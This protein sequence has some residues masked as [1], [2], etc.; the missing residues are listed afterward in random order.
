[1]E[2]E[3]LE[4]DLR[5]DGEVTDADR[6]YEVYLSNTGTKEGALK[7]L[8]VDENHQQI[9]YNTIV[10]PVDS[11][12]GY[13]YVLVGSESNFWGLTEVRAMSTGE[14]VA[15]EAPEVPEDEIISELTGDIT[16]G[17]VLTLTTSYTLAEAINKTV[18][19]YIARYDNGKLTDVSIS[20]DVVFEG[21][22]GEASLE[23]TITEDVTVQTE[24]KGFVWEKGTLIPFA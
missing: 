21:N 15:P 13:K 6:H 20:E 23:Y 1:M 22:T 8:G 14:E 17:S 10:L 7:I 2:I 5:A 4:I 3:N 24:F 11:T 9:P 16:K 19:L 18:N 12:Y